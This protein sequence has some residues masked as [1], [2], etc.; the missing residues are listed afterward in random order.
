[1]GCQLL[2]AGLESL[3]C[4]R[5]CVLLI[6]LFFLAS[7]EAWEVHRAPC[8]CCLALFVCVYLANMLYYAHAV[9]SQAVRSERRDLSVFF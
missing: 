9:R 2:E 7:A 4:P 3:W 5:V 6:L 1:M 8:C